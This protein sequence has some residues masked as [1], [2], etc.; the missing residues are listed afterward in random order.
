MPQPDG[1][2]VTVAKSI[3]RA[4]ICVTAV[5]AAHALV[6]SSWVAHIPHVKSELRRLSDGALGNALLGAPLGA[7]VATALCI[8]LLPR[9]GSHILVPVSL[10]G[11]AASGPLLGLAR[12]E[13]GHKLSRRVSRPGRAYFAK[14][15]R[16]VGWVCSSGP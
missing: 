13:L 7:L 4:Q 12:S 16:S 2:T 14:A 15:S 3:A 11:Y 5:F 8:R 6:F 9:W 1:R 10:A